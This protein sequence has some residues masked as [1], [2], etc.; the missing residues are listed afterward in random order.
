MSSLQPD[1]VN[2]VRGTPPHKDVSEEKA[3][4]MIKRLMDRTTQKMYTLSVEWKNP[5]DLIG[6]DHLSHLPKVALP[7]PAVHIHPSPLYS[8]P[9]QGPLRKNPENHQK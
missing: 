3:A 6:W 4:K 9:D 8:G 1:T 5:G 7:I 2:R